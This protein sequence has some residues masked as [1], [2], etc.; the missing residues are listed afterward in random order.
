MQMYKDV[1]GKTGYLKMRGDSG[2][3][4]SNMSLFSAD[5]LTDILKDGIEFYSP[6]A[7]VPESLA[8][9]K[10]A[11]VLSIIEEAN[12]RLKGLTAGYPDHEVQ[13][14]LFQRTEAQNYIDDNTYRSSILES[15]AIAFDT[16]ESKVA[17]GII[18][19]AIAY[20]RIVTDIIIR[21]KKSVKLIEEAKGRG[22][23]SLIEL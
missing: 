4:Y 18:E 8:N 12:Q 10:H 14:W 21:R 6:A 9:L 23:L 13:T 15:L 17:Y 22:D 2:R 7:V 19:K 1:N 20:E 3:L 5:E 16:T 11:K